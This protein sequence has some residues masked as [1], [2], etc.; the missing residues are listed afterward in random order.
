MT[1][2]DFITSAGVSFEDLCK[3]TEIPASTLSDII[4]GKAELSHCQARTIQKLAH[5]MG[6]SMD[7]L[8][9]ISEY[10]ERIRLSDY[11]QFK[12]KLEN[13]MGCGKA[14][15]KFCPAAAAD[16]EETEEQYEQLDEFMRFITGGAYKPRI[17]F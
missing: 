14:E 17:Y 2:Y 5:G 15:K 4:S 12:K 13:Q 8:M 9:D 10:I 6:L 7:E 16:F 3:M 11:L 1:F